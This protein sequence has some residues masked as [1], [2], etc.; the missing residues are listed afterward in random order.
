[1]IEAV[2]PDLVSAKALNAEILKIL[3]SRQPIGRHFPARK[4]CRIVMALR[5]A[6]GIFEPIQIAAYRPHPDH[7]GRRW[8]VERRGILQ[9]RRAPGRPTTRSSRWR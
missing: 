5:F 3:G 9:D 7:G 1:V 6:N 4:R 2:R 8:S